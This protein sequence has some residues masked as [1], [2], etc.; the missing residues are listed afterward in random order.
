M[1]VSNLKR[2]HERLGYINHN[3][4]RQLC[5]EGLLE[6]TKI[7]GGEDIFCEACQYGKQHR[8]PFKNTST[9][10]LSPGELIHSD[11]CGPMST[12]SIGGSKYFVSFKDDY[13]GYRVVYYIK[14]KAD[15]FDKLKEFTILI[16]NKFQR[17]VK[18]LRVDNGKEY[19]N[20]R[21]LRYLRGKGISLETT[22]P[23][24]PE[25]NGR[26]E[27][28]NRTIVESARAMLHAKNLSTRLWAEAVN[29]SRYILNRTPTSSNNGKTP[30]ELWTGKKPRLDHIRTFGSNAFVH[31]DKQFQ[32]KWDSKSRKMILIG[33]QEGTCNYRLFNLQT[34]KITTFR[35]IIIHETDDHSIASLDDN[36]KIPVNQELSNE[37]ETIEDIRGPRAS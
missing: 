18:T 13:S 6:G 22:A 8:L 2:W 17:S 19:N 26:A 16:E 29:T 34:W 20:E 28:D 32:K 35:N 23:Y 37:E 14:H 31:V 25:Q 15:V 5:K 1:T 24:T 21:T 27:R 33:Y 10:K 3:Y 9:K 7:N 12:E 36:V 4:I 11:V 30:F